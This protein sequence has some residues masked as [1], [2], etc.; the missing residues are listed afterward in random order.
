MSVYDVGYTVGDSCLFNKGPKKASINFDLTGYIERRQ[1]EIQAL[2]VQ[3][4]ELRLQQTRAVVD[5]DSAESSC[6]H[7]AAEAAPLATEA[8]PLATADSQ[9]R[10]AC[11]TGILLVVTASASLSSDPLAAVFV[12]ISE[13]NNLFA[14]QTGRKDSRRCDQN[15]PARDMMRKLNRVRAIGSCVID[16]AQMFNAGMIRIIYN[17]HTSVSYII[18]SRSIPCAE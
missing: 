8:A 18:L 16:G 11:S 15:N 7:S 12:S 17:A 1:T 4:D 6:F 3:M 5:N 2:D 14:G 10:T 9:H 13:L